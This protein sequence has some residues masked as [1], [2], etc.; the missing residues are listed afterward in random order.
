M[1]H[2][3][4]SENEYTYDCTGILLFQSYSLIQENKWILALGFKKEESKSVGGDTGFRKYY[5][6]NRQFQHLNQRKKILER[7][8][9]FN[10]SNVPIGT[11]SPFFA[12]PD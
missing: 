5:I 11:S 3:I 4:I 9:R 12:K 10:K 2:V 1:S 8:D 6:W 7:N